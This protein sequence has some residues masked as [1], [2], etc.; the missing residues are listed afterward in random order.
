MLSRDILIDR[1]SLFF[2]MENVIYDT[3]GY[4]VHAYHTFGS[5]DAV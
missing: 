3:V 2:F 1:V 5:V 4:R